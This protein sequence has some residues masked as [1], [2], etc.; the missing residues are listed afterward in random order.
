MATPAAQ[1]MSTF[2]ACSCFGRFGAAFDHTLYYVLAGFAWDHERLANPAN[3]QTVGGP[4]I[5][6]AQFSG[7]R[8]GGTV[9]AGI[10]YALGTNW[11]AFL[12]YNYMGFGRRAQVL[13]DTLGVV[14][15][16]TEIIREDFTWSKLALTTDSIGGRADLAARLDPPGRS[17]NFFVCKPVPIADEGSANPRRRVTPHR[18]QE[19]KSFDWL[20]L[21]RA[22]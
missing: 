10:E 21:R 14:P 9:G 18:I 11:T 22:S 12:Q 15:P 17:Q 5:A 19:T 3:V 13:S 1:P 2:E 6:D 7:T 20:P 4:T 16:F 8:Y